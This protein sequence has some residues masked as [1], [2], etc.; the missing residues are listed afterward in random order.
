[1]KTRLSALLA[2]RSFTFCV[3]WSG[4]TRSVPKKILPSR[5]TAI[6]RASSLSASGMGSGL[7]TLAM[8]TLTPFCSIGV[9]TMKMISST[10]ITSTIGVTLMLEFTLD[11]SSRFASAIGSTSPFHRNSAVYGYAG[12]RLPADSSATLQEVV[13]QLAR[14]VVHFHVECFHLAGEVVEHHDGRNR[15]EQSDGGGHQRFRNTACDRA[16]TGGLLRRNLL[17]RIQNADHRSQQPDEGCRRTDRRQTAQAALQLGVGDGF[18]ALQGTLRGFNLFAWNVGRFAVRPEFLQAGRDD[19]R[20]VALLIALGNLDGF[21]DLAFAQRAGHGGCESARLFAGGAERHRAVNHH[22]DRP[23]GHDEQNQ[24]NDLRQDSHLFPEGDRV[25]S[26]G[27]F[28]EHKDGD[29]GHVAESIGC[30]IG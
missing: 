10:S 19:L 15:H 16:Q 7:L 24:H 12:L 5:M 29:R 14:A 8:S 11:P 17:E 1:M 13:N 20:Q 4:S 26:H 2:R 25:P 9:M 30:N 6:S 28:L 18:G 21:V 27:A 22:A 3:S 23:S